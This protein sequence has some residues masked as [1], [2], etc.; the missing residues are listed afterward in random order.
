MTTGR[1][2]R[3][4]YAYVAEWEY[5]CCEAE[6][7]VGQRIEWALEA[8]P[9]EAGDASAI[10]DWIP[11]DE[12]D[13]VRFPGG[14]AG[15]AVLPADHRGPV[16]LYATWHQMEPA[17]TAYGEVVEVLP[18]EDG[19]M[20]G[21]RVRR[22]VEP[23]PAAVEQERARRD[24]DA[25]TIGLT[26]PAAAFG[27]DPPAVGDRMAIDLSDGRIS[28]TGG[29]SRTGV[30]HGVVRQVSR[31]ERTPGGGWFFY[32]LDADG[33]A[34]AELFVALVCDTRSVGPAS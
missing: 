34:P 2:P 25:R 8:C 10:A 28:Q 23:T 22:I 24:R 30:A 6:P 27:A 3:L 14:S 5:G 9:A 17:V 16:A 12:L 1:D 31:A 18:A 33:P 15:R 19:L 32:D 29:G 13:V 26:G 4:L 7:D 21:L 11:F 20:V